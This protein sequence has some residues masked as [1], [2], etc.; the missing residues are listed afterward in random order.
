[1]SAT[2]ERRPMLAH[3]PSCNFPRETKV[4]PLVRFWHENGGLPRRRKISV[5]ELAVKPMRLM[6]TV[7]E[8]QMDSRMFLP[9]AMQLTALH[10]LC[11]PV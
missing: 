7:Q 4:S 6:T 3:S 11:L 5:D 10:A 9:V 2:M 1:M 8:T